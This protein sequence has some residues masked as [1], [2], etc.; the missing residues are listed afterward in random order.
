M[1]RSNSRGMELKKDVAVHGNLQLLVSVIRDKME[2][3]SLADSPIIH[4]KIENLRE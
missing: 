1:D 2:D 4:W 3:H